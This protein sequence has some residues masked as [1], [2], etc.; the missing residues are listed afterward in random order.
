MVPVFLNNFQVLVFYVCQAAKIIVLIIGGNA[1]GAGFG[2]HTY[3]GLVG[4]D[5]DLGIS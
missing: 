1:V 3:Q 4:I 5:G 2:G